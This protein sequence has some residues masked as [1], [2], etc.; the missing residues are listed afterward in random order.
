MGTMKSLNKIRA[1]LHVTRLS[2]YMNGDFIEAGVA[3][4]GGTFPILYYLACTGLL[5][6]RKMHLFDT[7]EGLPAPVNEEDSGFQK[8]QYLVSL[9]GFWKN[10]ERWKEYYENQT[11][12]YTDAVSWGEAIEHLNLNVG[13]FHET[14]PQVLEA[15]HVVALFCDGDMY[16]S[17]LDC[18]ESASPS[19]LSRSYIYHDDYFSFSGNYEAVKFWR[20]K[21]HD[22]G[23]ILIVPQ[24]DPFILHSELSSPCKPPKGNLGSSGGTCNGKKVEAAFWQHLQIRP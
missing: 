9:E 18:L 11:S 1:A 16:Q 13:L 19:L 15:K 6:G 2:T 8:G 21:S 22:V 4:G 23:E 7:W 17:S 3:E 20:D 12:I 5:R 24:A 10:A 14:M